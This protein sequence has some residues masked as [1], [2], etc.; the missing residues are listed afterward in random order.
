MSSDEQ[1]TTQKVLIMP[2]KGEETWLE[3]FNREIREEQERTA[4]ELA[5][6]VRD[7]QIARQEGSQ[8]GESK[9]SPGE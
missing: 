2:P 9:D 4:A 1:M 7:A 5:R 6:M 3:K 8:E